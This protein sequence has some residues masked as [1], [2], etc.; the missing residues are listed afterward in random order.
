M[1]F[2]AIRET[3]LEDK[4]FRVLQFISNYSYVAKVKWANIKAIFIY[5][6]KWT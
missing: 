4:I 2:N 3:N 1:R 5:S 6:K